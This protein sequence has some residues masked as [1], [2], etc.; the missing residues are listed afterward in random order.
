MIRSGGESTAFRSASAPSEA[1]ITLQT[2]SRAW[3]MS[4]RIS[5]LSSTMRTFTDLAEGFIWAAAFYLA[6]CACALS[7]LEVGLA[8]GIAA[9]APGFFSQIDI[10]DFDRLIEGLAHVVDGERCR[11]NRNKRFHFHTGLRRGL[12]R[13]R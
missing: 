6:F 7:S 4:S 11:S 1:M 9:L 2:G 5:G 3:A 13:A 8:Q 12:R 10:R